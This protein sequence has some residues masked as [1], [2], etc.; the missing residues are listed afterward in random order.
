LEI[1]ETSAEPIP[2]CSACSA[3]LSARDRFCGHCG[4]EVQPLNTARADVFEL[5]RPTL[6]FYFITLLL[7]SAYKLTNLFP[8]G[9]DSL[10]IVSTLDTAI[11]I[12]FWVNYRKE[13]S[14][15]LAVKRINLRLI[16]LTITGAAVGAL[17]VYVIADLI[18][19]SVFK[20]VYYNPY[21]FED[22]AYPLLFIVLFTCVQPAIFEEVAFRG[23]LLTNIH[24]VTSA[25]GAMYVTSFVFGIIH[26][27]FLALLWLVPIGLVFAWLRIRYNTLWYGMIGHFAYNFFI[28]LMEYNGFSIAQIF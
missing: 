19:L 10:L 11:V 16:A 9:F 8:E 6:A 5:I 25:R 27:S 22:T 4:K 15:L 7:L 26:L 17:I 2:H 13:I 23:F 21:L 1:I 24:A 28:S 14:E 12:I 20:D 18:N 3:E